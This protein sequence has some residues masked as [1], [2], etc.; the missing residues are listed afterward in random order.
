MAFTRYASCD[1]EI[2][3]I[4]G[5]PVKQVTASLDKLSDFE[6][7]RTDQGYMYVRI[8]AISSRVNKNHDGWPSVELAGSPEIFNQHKA[9]AEGFV[10]E[11]ADGNR[12][13]GFAT[14]VGKPIFVDHNN[15]DPKKARGVIVD[16]KFRVLDQ[17]TASG[18]DYWDSG[19]VDPEHLPPS[20]VELLLEVDAKEYPKFAKQILD[21]DLDGFSM[22]ANVE[23]TK[24][25]HCGN[26]AHDPSEFCSHVRMKGATHD[27]KTAD[28]KRISK[29]S[30]ENCYKCAFFE[31]SGVF[32]PAD[33]TALA[34]EVKAG[35]GG[36]SLDDPGGVETGNG[37][38]GVRQPDPVR[39]LNR[40]Q[41][42]ENH[43]M[44]LMNT[45]QYPWNQAMSL[46][47]EWMNKNNP[48]P[49]AGEGTPRQLQDPRIIQGD[50]RL[51][52]FPGTIPY[53]NL[54]HDNGNAMIGNDPYLSSTR[55][56]ENPLPQE[57]MTRAP[58]EIDTLRDEQTCPVCGAD[59]DEDTCPVCNY[60]KPPSEFDN[61]D[62]QEAQKIRAE[63]R[64][65]DEASVENPD[66]TPPPSPSAGPEGKSQIPSKPP[67]TASVK[68]DMRAW[69]PKLDP[70]TAAKINT[71]ETPVR[72]G[73]KPT[74][75]EPS[76]QTVLKDQVI[77][78]TSAMRTAQQ[79]ME[80]TRMN[81]TA[82]GPTPPGDT[83]ADKRVDV[84]G[85]GGVDNASNEEASKAHATNGRGDNAGYTQTDVTGV[86]G[87][88]EERVDADRTEDLSTAGRESDD[89]GF[90][91][92]KT[93]EDSGPTKTY[94]DRDGQHSGVTDPVTSEKP[95]FDHD[96]FKGSY[97]RPISYEDGTLEGLDQQGGDNGGLQKQSPS[98]GV[99]PVAEQF[100]ERVDLTEHKT[101]PENN[102]GP[103]KTWSGTDGNGVLKQQDPVTR[104]DQ[105][106]GNVKVPD[107]KLHT[108][109]VSQG[110]VS[111]RMIN[112]MRLADAEI[113][114]GLL[115]KA[116]KYNR[117]AA[118]AS[119]DPSRV[120]ERIR[121][122]A[123]VKTAGQAKLAQHKMATKL[124]RSFGKQTA[125]SHDFERIASTETTSA[126]TVDDSVLDAALFTR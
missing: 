10:V 27:I 104:E 114:L 68:G 43:A 35:F 92:D 76:S 93:T 48:L 26:V 102:S 49:G 70:R 67:A 105:E 21:G 108:P 4:K 74:S 17:K 56:A 11:A 52:A 40:R 62:L 124:P 50:P 107:V 65:G 25:S 88:G 61:P 20:E 41:E 23:Y 7:Y 79:L 90:N 53:E 117:I 111:S 99:Q 96:N 19:D 45:Y 38:F 103:T 39:S 3:E 110:T 115:D 77:P 47:E 81:R 123:Q 120:D 8:R 84:V 6:N 83:S 57:M 100:G 125:A 85:V 33:E 18:D 97:Y 64:E 37:L 9:A 14:F 98:R 46:A 55:T 22:G 106:W 95:W 59:M 30:Y 71:N 1:A 121:T 116:D 80:R 122:L 91:T 44:M 75:N 126:E 15:T 94:D 5:S 113:E 24:C 29:K 89:S 28:G 119:G 118:L 112:A 54:Q 109:A 66:P 51:K 2:L 60:T 32:E 12:N 87:T 63:M 36:Q 31:I 73:S 69:I 58:E 16:S 101:S 34:R 82:D 42:I 86:G 13:Y 78:V 72:G